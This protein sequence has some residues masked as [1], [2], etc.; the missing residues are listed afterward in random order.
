MLNK[1]FL[2]APAA[3]GKVPTITVIGH[4][5]RK[6]SGDLILSQNPGKKQL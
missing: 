4:S 6:G 5:A 2:E 3:E 1:A